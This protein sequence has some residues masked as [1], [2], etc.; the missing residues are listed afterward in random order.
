MIQKLL[1]NAE[2]KWMIF[3]KIIKKKIQMEN[4]KYC[5]YLMI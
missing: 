2:M 4:E 1:L 3:I 5:F